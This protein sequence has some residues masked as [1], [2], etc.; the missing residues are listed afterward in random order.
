MTKPMTGLRVAVLVANGFDE[1]DLL[2]VQ[3]LLVELGATMRIVSTAQGLVNGWDGQGWGHN[4]AVDEQINTALGADFDRLVIPGGQRS[5]DKLKLTAHTKRFISSFMAAMKPVAV[6]GDALQIMGV[7]EQLAGRTVAGPQDFQAE[8]EKAG[9][10]WSGDPVQVDGNLLTGVSGEQGRGALTEALTA[11]L[12]QDN[13]LT[14][15][16]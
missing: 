12:V 14:Q 4:F 13:Q 10:V 7:T 5:F 15:A 6:I 9:A 1:G 16:A 3:R 11:F 2:A 8:A